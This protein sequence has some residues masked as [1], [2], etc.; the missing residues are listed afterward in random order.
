MNSKFDSILTREAVAVLILVGSLSVPAMAQQTEPTTPPAQVQTGTTNAQTPGAMNPDD[1]G[2]YATGQPLEMKSNEGFWGKVNPFARKKWVGRQLGPVK[3]R[4]NE[5]DQLNA[6]NAND[7]KDVDGRAQ[8]GIHKAQTAAEQAAQQAAEAGTRAGQAQQVAQQATTHTGQLQT[9]VSNLDQYQPVTDTEIHFRPGQATL[10]AKAKE[11][12][13]G[14]SGQLNGKQ[15]YILEV[16]GY[17]RSAGQAGIQNSQR[18]S[19]AVVRYLVTEHQ[20]P[21]YRIHQLAMGNAKYESST[22]SVRGTVVHV[23]LMQNSLAT[24]TSAP[25]DAGSPSGVTQQ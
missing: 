24:M 21:V 13:D 7:I 17:S 22:G 18:M 20:V 8:Q 15:G 2:T 10:N 3:D 23:S 19:N 25:K 16:Q 4:L 12:L 9:T 14:I 1:K 6:K 5:L 11:A